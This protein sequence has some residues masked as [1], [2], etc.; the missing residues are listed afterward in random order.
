MH[1]KIHRADHEDVAARKVHL[2]DA[3]KRLRE[4]LSGDVYPYKA[5]FSPVPGD[6]RRFDVSACRNTVF[7]DH[8]S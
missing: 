2:A 6:A 5:S 3:H 7:R 4:L 8:R 1:K